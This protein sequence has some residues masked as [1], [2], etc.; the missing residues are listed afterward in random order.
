[1]RGIQRARFPW[2]ERSYA[3]VRLT[4]GLADHSCPGAR[5]STE[6]LPI[7]QPGTPPEVSARS[8]SWRARTLVMRFDRGTGFP[9][10]RPPR[11]AEVGRFHWLAACRC[12]R[13]IRG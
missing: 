1:M 9:E 12:E 11:R 13:T 8:C 10:S 6:P 4:A 2:L 3:W 7:L 5:E